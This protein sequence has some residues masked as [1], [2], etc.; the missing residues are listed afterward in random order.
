MKLFGGK[1]SGKKKGS[2]K[3]GLFSPQVSSAGAVVP[4][5]IVLSFPKFEN[6]ESMS[7][8]EICVACHGCCSYVTIPLEY[9]RSRTKIEEYRWYLV[10][11]NVEIFIDHDSEWQLLFKTPC[12][13][14]DGKGYCTIYETRPDIC[15][16]YQADSCSR[17]GS[18]HTHLFAKPEEL[19][20]Y[21]DE[22]KGKRKK[23]TLKSAAKKKKKNK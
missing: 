13:Y 14:L 1:T 10:H 4:P 16:E 6:E 2:K 7:E 19:L 17:V 11:R 3:K 21:L 22:K 8:S 23:T 18:D 9:P 20:A 12:D 5:E 15:R